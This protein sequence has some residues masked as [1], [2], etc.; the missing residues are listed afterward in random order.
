MALIVS[1]PW[2]QQTVICEKAFKATLTSL[3]SIKQQKDTVSDKVLNI[4]KH[5]AAT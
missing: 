4:A 5:L 3:L 2:L 1:L